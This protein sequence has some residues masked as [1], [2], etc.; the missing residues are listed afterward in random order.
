MCGFVGFF[1]EEDNQARNTEI[2]R[3]MSDRIYHRGPDQ[4]DEYVDDC[5]SLGFRRL[6]IMDVEGGTSLL[7]MRMAQ[8]YFYLM[9]KSMISSHSVK[10]WKRLVTYSRHIQTRK[11][12]CTAMKSGARDCLHVFVV[13][14]RL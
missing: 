13:C 8:R 11:Y 14:S 6:S 5:V 1:N 7:Q 10:N 9:V 2:V 12:F 4:G 3:A